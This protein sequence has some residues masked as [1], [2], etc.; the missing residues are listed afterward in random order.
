MT[1][2]VHPLN[3]KIERLQSENTQEWSKREKL[4]SDKLA[5]ERENKKLRLQIEVLSFRSLS[6]SSHAQLSHLRD[7]CREFHRKI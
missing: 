2:S 5:L 1:I 3:F 4:E 7:V 6:I